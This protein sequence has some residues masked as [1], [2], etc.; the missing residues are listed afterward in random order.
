[1]SGSNQITMSYKEHCANHKQD[2]KR[3]V[4]TDVVKSKN[5]V[6]Y[7]KCHTSGTV[8]KVVDYIKAH[9]VDKEGLGYGNY[10]AILSG[11]KATGYIV[12]IYCH[13][14]NVNNLVEGKGIKKGDLIGQM[15]S[16]G[17]SSGAHI[18]FE[19]RKMSSKPKVGMYMGWNPDK[20]TFEWINPEPYLNSD[21]PLKEE[22]KKAVTSKYYLHFGLFS[23]KQNACRMEANL[24]AG[25]IKATIIE[26]N[27][28]Y[29]VVA[30]PSDSYE[31]AKI[32]MEQLKKEGFTVFIWQE[33][34]N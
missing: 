21:L 8:I 19:L 23:Y 2:W 10:V 31:Q 3:A 11:K 7:I 17:S 27:K 13:L 6:D 16:T 26:D 34:G 14:A 5:Q 12:H 33:G 4:G 15:G 30:Y 1:M 24:Q 32:K 28:G 20:N 18:H 25:K 9:E 29:H 22:S